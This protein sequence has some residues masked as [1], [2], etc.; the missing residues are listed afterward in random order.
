ML[1]ACRPT[2]PSKQSSLGTFT[3]S[4][5]AGISSRWWSSTLTPD[6]RAERSPPCWG[7]SQVKARQ[8]FSIPRW[9]CRSMAG[10]LRKAG[11]DQF[12]TLASTT[13]DARLLPLWALRVPPPLRNFSPSIA[14]GLC[15][16][17]SRPRRRGARARQW[18]QGLRKSKRRRSRLRGG[19]HSRPGS[20]EFPPLDV[21]PETVL[22]LLT[23]V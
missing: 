11:C 1:R 16:M 9:M 21:S 13:M 4:P 7:S 19:S 8:E 18:C 2:S 20:K 15:R 17:W 6:L 3:V 14:L 12:L 23:N 10:S 22:A 5:H